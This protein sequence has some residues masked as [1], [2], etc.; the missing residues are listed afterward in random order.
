[1]KSVFDELLKKRPE[2]LVTG[3][4]I[5]VDNNGA[6]AKIR[7]QGETAVW[8]SCSISVDPGDTVIVY[9]GATRSVLQRLASSA[10]DQVTLILV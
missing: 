7:I 1:M 9:N 2:N 6:R 3:S 4:V 10:A 5:A 8:A